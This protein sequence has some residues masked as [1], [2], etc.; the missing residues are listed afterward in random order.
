M[1]THL[2]PPP[3]GL[4]FPEGGDVAMLEAADGV[5]LRAVF[6]P[7]PSGSRRGTVF[8]FQGRTEFIEKYGEVFA[9]LQQRGFA[10][11]AL[12]W[13]GQGGSERLLRN[14]RKGHVD[15]FDD[16]LLDM[17]ALIAEA[18]RREMPEPFGLL[19]HSMGSA[20]ALM[21]LAHGDAPFTRAVMSS[22]MV[23]LPG[24]AGSLFARVIAR[25]L[26]SIGLSGM[27]VPAGGAKSALEKPFPGNPLT[28]DAK[29]FADCGKWL[30][31]EPMLAL[32]DPTIG[33]VDAAFEAMTDF[34]EANF[35]H[36]S[37]TPVLMLVAGTDAIVDH[38]ASSALARRM[39][40]ASAISIRQAQHEILIETDAIQAEFWAAFDAFMSLGPIP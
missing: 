24:L 29:R 35:G 28:S 22:P 38:H 10:V 14:P 13:R 16:Y 23:R 31:A 5:T 20:I 32:G 6:F 7:S 40:G 19:S 18:R 26:A 1:L 11:T 15:D 25:M 34:S 3:E 17:D 36:A 21:R 2:I 37:R 8:V 33:W 39:R 27:Y 12:D 30:E 9:R 4:T